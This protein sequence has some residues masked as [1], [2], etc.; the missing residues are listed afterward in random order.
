MRNYYDILLDML[1]C[2]LGYQRHAMLPIQ[3]QTTYDAVDDDGNNSNR[4]T[5]VS[6]AEVGRHRVCCHCAFSS[7]LLHLILVH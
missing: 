2:H 3:N 6:F 4:L 1:I 7:V 5:F